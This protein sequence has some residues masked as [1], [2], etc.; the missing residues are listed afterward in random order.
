MPSGVN[1]VS[2]GKMD[3]DKTIE[4][5]RRVGPLVFGMSKDTVLS[6][7]G[8]PSYEIEETGGLV[9]R[10]LGVLCGFDEDTQRLSSVEIDSSSGFSLSGVLLASSLQRLKGQLANQGIEL[11][12]DRLR[13]ELYSTGKARV[14]V[15]I[16][17]DAI[18]GIVFGVPFDESGDTILWP[19]E[20]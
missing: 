17:D 14:R 9:Y 8:E 11:V 3:M 12:A 19:D 1:V 6:I 13:G 5:N 7:L 4:L 2:E 16:E 15:F 18:S 10:M 20:T